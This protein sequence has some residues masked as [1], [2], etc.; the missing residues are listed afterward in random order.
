MQDRVRWMAEKKTKKCVCIS[1]SLVAFHFS[2]L[3]CR[4]SQSRHKQ[5]SQVCKKTRSKG[6]QLA[7]G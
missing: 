4:N 5:H 2:Q 1:V 6:H 7:Q 3:T